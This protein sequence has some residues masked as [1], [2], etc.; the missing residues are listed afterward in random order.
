MTSLYRLPPTFKTCSRIL[1]QGVEEFVGHETPYSAQDAIAKYYRVGGLNN[2]DFFLTVLESGRPRPGCQ[3]GWIW[4]RA[5]FLAVCLLLTVSSHVK[6]RSPP[7]L[8]RTL[9]LSQGLPCYPN[10]ITAQ[11]PHLQI[12]SDQGVGL[13]HM[14]LG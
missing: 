3:H 11:G 9:T 10:V 7:R 1:S 2:R 8:I 5:L 13:Q 4:V 12:S 14:N 6:L